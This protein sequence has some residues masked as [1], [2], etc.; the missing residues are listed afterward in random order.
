M[1]DDD[2]LDV[3]VNFRKSDGKVSILLLVDTPVGL[4]LY[5]GD[6]YKA[7]GQVT[8]AT[9]EERHPRTGAISK[10]KGYSWWYDE[11]EYGQATGRAFTT[12]AAVAAILAAG[13][14]REAP[15]N[16]TNQGLF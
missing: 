16:A 5:E 10:K 9:W 6:V 8:A 1:G 15:P 11:E 13:G 14:Y 2:L 7:I 12:K 3:M 4:A